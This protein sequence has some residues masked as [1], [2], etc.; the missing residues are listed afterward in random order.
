MKAEREKEMRDFLDDCLKRGLSF[1]EICQENNQRPVPFFQGT[2]YL[3]C[4]EQDWGR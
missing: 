2:I 1:W 4:V 3:Y